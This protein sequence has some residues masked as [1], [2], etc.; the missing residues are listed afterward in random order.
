VAELRER[1]SQIHGRRGLADAALLVRDRDAATTQP[2]GA[3][4]DGLGSRSGSIT[5]VFG[6]GYAGRNMRPVAVPGAFEGGVADD[7]A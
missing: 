6:V 1:R 2:C 7:Y 4:L 5:F 3:R